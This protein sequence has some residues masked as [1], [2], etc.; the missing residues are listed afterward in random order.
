MNKPQNRNLY[1]FI[2]TFDV[3][4]VAYHFKNVFNSRKIL[5]PDCREPHRT[6]FLIFCYFLFIISIHFGVCGSSHLNWITCFFFN[7]WHHWFFPPNIEYSFQHNFSFLVHTSTISASNN[8]SVVRISFANTHSHKI[9]QM[10][11]HQLK[12]HEL[13]TKNNIKFRKKINKNNTRFQKRKVKEWVTQWL[14]AQYWTNVLWYVVFFEII[15]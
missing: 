10:V 15:W 2:D 5:S 4:L 7:F 14:A 9:V 12:M 8:F 1:P 6:I 13:E 11:S 3:D